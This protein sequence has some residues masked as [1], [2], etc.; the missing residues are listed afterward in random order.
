MG[1]NHYRVTKQLPWIE[2][3]E[4]APN[5]E[6]V[7]G[8]PIVYRP[9]DTIELDDL[10]VPSIFHCLEATNAA[11]QA[12]LD[13]ARARMEEPAKVSMLTDFDPKDQ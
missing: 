12:V 8:E 6:W 11:G 7:G 1:R 10:E 9:G 13:V 3:G 4:L 5:F 2:G